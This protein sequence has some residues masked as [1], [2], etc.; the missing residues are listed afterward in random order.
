MFKDTIYRP[1][2][3]IAHENDGHQDNGLFNFTKERKNNKEETH[4]RIL[5]YDNP[6]KGGIAF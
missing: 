6:T 5:I 4:Y 2:D 1:K 3:Q